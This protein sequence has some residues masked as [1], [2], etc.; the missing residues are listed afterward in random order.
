[1]MIREVNKHLTAAIIQVGLNRSVQLFLF[2]SLKLQ[3]LSHIRSNLQDPKVSPDLI[4]QQ[5]I[6]EHSQT[7][8]LLVF[9]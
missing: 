5:K 6:S 2:W 1:M 3:R 9:D 4:L 7:N 8:V